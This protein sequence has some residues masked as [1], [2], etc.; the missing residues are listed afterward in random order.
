MRSRAGID[1]SSASRIIGYA[2]FSMPSDCPNAS[3]SHADSFGRLVRKRESPSARRGN[4]VSVAP[5]FSA[6]NLR[7]NEDLE[8]TDMT[9]NL[10]SAEAPAVK[11]APESG[12]FDQISV[13]LHWLTVLLIVVQFTTAW[14]REAVD[15]ETS[16]AVAIL[17]IHRSSGVLTW[18]I[19][20]G[21]LVWRHNFAHLPP[22]PNSMPKLQ[23][24]IAKANE[25][26]LYIL[27]FVQ[28][29]T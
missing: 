9:K 2:F 13:A 21:R 11:A 5:V 4:K 25:Y 28:P 16:L 18:I 3:K 27:L 20:L 26:G 24:T 19:G 22:F 10:E 6:T 17:T 23:Q 12:R 29:I 14:L 7:P 15:H 8:Q 1:P